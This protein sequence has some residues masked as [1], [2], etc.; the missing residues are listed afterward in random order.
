MIERSRLRDLLYDYDADDID[1]PFW[2]A[3]ARHEF[4]VYRCQI[5]GR[6]YWPGC[7]CTLDGNKDMK[8]VRASGRGV[9]HTFVI[10]RHAYTPEMADQVPYNVCVIKLEEGPFFHSNVVDC[11][12]E[13]LRSGTLVEV[14]FHG[15]PSGLTLPL[16]RRLKTTSA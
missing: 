4:L 1:M 5:C 9:V 16:F 8:W 6:S 15:H 13:E 3:C 2:D 12:P 14:E 11:P 7:M 10:V